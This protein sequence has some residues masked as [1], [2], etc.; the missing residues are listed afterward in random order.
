MD[1]WRSAAIH[2]D[3]DER[4][5]VRAMALVIVFSDMSRL[6]KHSELHIASCSRSL[7]QASKCTGAEPHTVACACVGMTL[8]L[9]GG[10]MPDRAVVCELCDSIIYKERCTRPVVAWHGHAAAE[11]QRQDAHIQ[12]SATGAGTRPSMS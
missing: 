8:L 7:Y 6:I 4:H 12:T 9:A 1:G 5:V 3:F 10:H 2:S 11:G